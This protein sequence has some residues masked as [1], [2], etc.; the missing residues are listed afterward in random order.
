MST[1]SLFSRLEKVEA[2]APAKP[3]KIFVYSIDND[4]AEDAHTDR[5]IEA[6]KASPDGDR[7]EPLIVRYGG[8]L[9]PRL[10]DGSKIYN[11]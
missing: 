9:T 10:P 8:P 2:H 5:E 11:A 7:F 3:Y 4:P 6:F 1:Q